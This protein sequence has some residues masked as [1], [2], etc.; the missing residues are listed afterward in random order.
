MEFSTAARTEDVYSND[1]PRET[2]PM[3]VAKQKAFALTACLAVLAIAACWQTKPSVA[4]SDNPTSRAAALNRSEP[5]LAASWDQ[6]AAAAYLDRRQEWWMR[7]PRSQRDH[8]T[9]CVS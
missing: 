2:F 4:A 3:N 7:W 8:D 6:K 1:E 9:F 5:K